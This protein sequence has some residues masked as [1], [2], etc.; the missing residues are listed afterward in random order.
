MRSPSLTR[1][2]KYKLLRYVQFG[3]FLAKI[4]QLRQVVIPDIWLVRMING[5]VLMIRFRLIKRLEC[6][7]LSYN[8]PIKYFSLV[9][10]IYVT[11]CNTLLVFVRVKDG[12]AILSAN[13]RAL[14]V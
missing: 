3:K 14:P 8:R 2:S 11:F 4:C 10:L 12:R 6:D 7:D 9:Q 5:V 1:R 13:V